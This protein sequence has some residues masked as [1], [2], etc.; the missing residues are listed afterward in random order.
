MKN[1][2]LST[3]IIIDQ[4]TLNGN[5]YTRECLER[6]IRAFNVQAKNFHS[7]GSL[8]DKL[9]IEKVGPI[10]HRVESLSINDSG[11]VYATVKILDEQLLQRIHN[12]LKVIARPI[13]SVPSFELDKS[14]LRVTNIN[15]IIRVQLECDNDQ[16]TGN[17]ESHQT[18]GQ[19][20]GESSPNAGT[21]I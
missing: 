14:P 12:G 21:A 1:I 9:H 5:V 10:T 17:E 15:K 6:A 19:P 7:T 3:G 13:I 20:N 4:P 18:G 11:V 16:P 2:I 8:I